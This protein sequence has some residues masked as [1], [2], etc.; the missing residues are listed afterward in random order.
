MNSNSKK[1][2]LLER[3]RL[4]EESE[5]R[6]ASVPP[7]PAFDVASYASALLPLH[8][9]IPILNCVAVTSKWPIEHFFFSLPL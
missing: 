9:N 3:E 8:E 4:L 5:L 6:L 2:V 7:G 1:K